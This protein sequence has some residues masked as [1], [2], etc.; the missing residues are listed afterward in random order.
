MLSRSG[1][2]AGVDS[3]ESVDVGR[4]DERGSKVTHNLHVATLRN[5]ERKG[6]DVTVAALQPVVYHVD[7]ESLAAHGLAPHA[8]GGGVSF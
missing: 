4:L 1:T 8:S 2:S 6:A 5:G 3:S 7:S